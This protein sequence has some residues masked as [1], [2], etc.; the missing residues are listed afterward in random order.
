LYVL[1]ERKQT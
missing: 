1:A